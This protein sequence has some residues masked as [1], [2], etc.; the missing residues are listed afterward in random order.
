MLNVQHISPDTEF[1]IKINGVLPKLS[2]DLENE[3]ERLW[4]AEHN[5]RGK[6]IFNGRIM[7]ASTVSSDGIH[8][9]IVEYR[10][11]IAQRSRPELFK[12]LQV[13]PVA[14]SGLLECA[15]GI[16]FGRRADSMTQDAGL[17]E[18][19]PSGGIDTSKINDERHSTVKVDFLPQ[20]LIELHQE[21]GIKSSF[22][23]SVKPFCLVDDTD[24][25][26]LDIGIAIE[27][28]L[29]YNEILTTHRDTATK[30][31]D[32]LRLVPRSEINQFIQNEASQLV[33]VSAALI[34]H[35]RK[36]TSLQEV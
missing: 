36:S 25:H 11:L 6:A 13:R 5:R 29:S 23:S 18:L 34:Q 10:H 19:V 1:T 14:V 21:I 22:V 7:S 27:L 28:P 26:T 3:V 24:S 2:A 35:F 17:W 20:I 30:E 4:L 31:Y 8:G 33:G 12:D 32:K 16:V 15:D 9:Y